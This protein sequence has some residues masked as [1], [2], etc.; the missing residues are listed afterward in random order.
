MTRST[1]EFPRS[2]GSHR[3]LEPAP[4]DDCTSPPSPTAITTAPRR[5]SASTLRPKPAR[6]K[7]R[8]HTTPKLTPS[9]FEKLQA[10]A[11]AEMRSVANYVA[12]LVV[13]PLKGQGRRKL[14]PLPATRPGV[15]RVSYEIAIPL[16]PDQRAEL[17]AKAQK[18]M[19]SVSSYVALVIAENLRGSL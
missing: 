11:A 16:T 6:P 1:L 3:V 12:F 4:S 9:E 14:R 15:D 18:Q 8:I 2:R 17:E 7:V 19:R 10:R 13:Q 5:S